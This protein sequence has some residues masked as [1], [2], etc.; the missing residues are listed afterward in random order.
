[1]GPP[2]FAQPALAKQPAIKKTPKIAVLRMSVLTAHLKRTT[3]AKDLELIQ[4]KLGV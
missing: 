2:F 1:M 3:A 4:K